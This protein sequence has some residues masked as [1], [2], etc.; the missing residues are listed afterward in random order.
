MNNENKAVE[1]KHN[2]LQWIRGFLKRLDANHMKVK[3]EGSDIILQSGALKSPI[4]HVRFRRHS[5]SVWGMDIAK[6]TGGWAE[7]PYFGSCEDM[8]Y[9]LAQ[10]FE[11]V[12]TKVD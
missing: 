12:L 9:I 7:T 5:A 11:W 8:M 4:Y 1:I 6:H 2:D 10:S 3:R